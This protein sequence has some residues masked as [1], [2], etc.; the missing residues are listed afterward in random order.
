MTVLLECIDLNF[1]YFYKY[2]SYYSLPSCYYYAGII[3]SDVDQII[4]IIT[5]SDFC[6]R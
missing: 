5:A 2:T 3:G 4:Y 1:S 6:Y